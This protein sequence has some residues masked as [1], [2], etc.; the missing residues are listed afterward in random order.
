MIK[1][2]NVEKTLVSFWDKISCC[3][4]YE[5]RYKHNNKTFLATSKYS[6]FRVDNT[7]Q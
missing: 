4:V 5:F 6:F 7:K 2:F 1:Y 3:N